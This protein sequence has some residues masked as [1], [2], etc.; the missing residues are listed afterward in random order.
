MLQV[1]GTTSNQCWFNTLQNFGIGRNGAAG[2]NAAGVRYTNTLV[3]YTFNVYSF[4]SYYCFYQVNGSGAGQGH[5]RDC[6]AGT[7][8]HACNTGF[9]FTNTNGTFDSTRVV[10]CIVSTATNGFYVTSTGDGIADIY[11]D[12]C[13]SA[14]CQYGHYLSSSYHSLGPFFNDNVHL[15][16]CI[17]DGIGTSG[18]SVN[19]VYGASAYIDIDS[20]Y[21]SG[22]LNNT[23]L[24]DIENSA[25]VNIR[26][27]DIRPSGT[28]T[29]G[30]LVNGSNCNG[31]IIESNQFMPSGA[32]TPYAIKI[33]SCSNVVITNNVING[34]SASY[35]W[36]VGIWCVSATYALIQGNSL[37][38]YFTTGVTLDSGSSHCGGVNSLNLTAGTAVSD[39]GTNDT[40]TSI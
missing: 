30:I 34:P 23:A 35:L 27:C 1:S 4:D 31:I 28:T 16:R 25:G 39:S 3:V 33:A 11:F 19:N 20:C 13:E 5:F 10:D 8:A 21:V 40:V 29:D 12:G 26:G 7:N 9:Y 2:T 17:H 6:Q 38:G 15:I 22:A 36:T 32:T 24:I 37:S 18:I 14:S